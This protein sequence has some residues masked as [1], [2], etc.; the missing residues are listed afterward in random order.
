MVIAGQIY[1]TRL[2]GIM[3]HLWKDNL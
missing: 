2:R 3:E 1:R